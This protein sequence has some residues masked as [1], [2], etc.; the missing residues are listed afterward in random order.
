MLGLG[1]AACL[2][3]AIAAW[4]LL[5]APELPVVRMVM[6]LPAYEN[7][8][9][10]GINL[11]PP[12]VAITPDGSA[13]IYTG[14]GPVATV[15]PGGGQ[16]FPAGQFAVG[17]ASQLWI[18]RL[19][20]LDARPMPG[21]ENGWAPAVSPDGRRVAFTAFAETRADIRVAPLDG[22][23]PVT[24]A[25]NVGISSPSWGPGDYV[26]F[27]DPSGLRVLRVPASGGPLDTVTT[28]DAFPSGGHLEWPDILP[29]GKRALVTVGVQ[30]QGRLSTHEIRMLDLTTGAS[31]RLAEG[32]YARYSASGHM[33]YITA[34]NVLMAVP[35]DAR[36]GKTT[37]RP[38][39]LVEGV[40]YRNNGAGDLAISASGS[41][42]YTQPGLNAPEVLVWADRTGRVEALDSAWTGNL[43][44]EALALSPDGTRLAVEIVGAASTLEIASFNRG[45][46]WIKQLPRG[47]LSR[48]TFTGADNRTPAWSPD[49]K[50]VAYLS[51]T[52]DGTWTVVR[53]PAD[54]SGT[55]EVL[56]TP[57][58][59]M[60][61]ISWSADGAWLLGGIM[62]RPND[63]IVALR[64]GRDTAWMVV[65]EGPGNEY[66][67]TLSPDG[68]W[69]A[70]V[71][72]ESGQAEVY[73]RPFPNTSSG[74]W[75]I[76]SGGGIDPTW[77]ANGGEVYYRSF[78]GNT[79]RAASMAGGP[80]NA[81]RRTVTRIPAGAYEVN[82]RNRL[83]A[84]TRDGQR[85][86]LI[87][88][89]GEGDVSGQM[90]F[91]QNILA[92]LR[93]KAGR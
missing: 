3:A 29:D 35:F 4:A 40:D 6:G 37:G 84:V 68:R 79:I 49:G 69:L 58:R 31:A 17:V 70:Y 42:I 5:R 91:V 30:T 55:P 39:A 2:A 81:E 47:P 32:V 48:L 11:T 61:D 16:A 75:Q 9:Y 46:I 85:F 66:E 12:R 90:V 77:S 65:A 51:R 7:L 14:S 18:R 10:G 62:G 74:K 56:P 88:Q 93:A 44:F 63:D 8:V 54:G 72:D 13:I 36:S 82:P 78:D 53:R 22:G 80:S 38:V 71:S 1:A 60:H 52:E 89:T 21:T 64:P 50:S 41:M 73:V 19:N 25:S 92:D 59:E 43:E 83:M 15:L 34:D 26:Y 24:V 27:L 20:E 33:L 23:P 28:V 86:L 57:P 45:D 76:S 87:N 67:P